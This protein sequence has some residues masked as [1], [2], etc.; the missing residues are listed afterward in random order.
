MYKK[1]IILI[2]SG[3]HARVLLDIIIQKNEKIH[4]VFDIKNELDNIFFKYPHIKLETE[5]IKNFNPRE[6][7]MINGLGIIPGKDFKKR[8]K[9][10]NKF[11]DLGFTFG[12]LIHHSAIVSKSTCLLGGINIMA[13]A[14]I[15]PGVKISSNSIINTGA[16]LDHDCIIGKNVHIA[17]G[18]IL[19]GSVKVGDSSFIGAGA[20]IL[21][22]TSVP[23][24]KIIPA[25]SVYKK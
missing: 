11:I 12:S 20:I 2:G 14:V 25:G 1:K 24:N 10:F 9:I 22:G 3:G 13:G 15:Q 23:E 6:F 18:A 7:S 4:A 8:E 21:P 17:P 19:C 5:L 16:K